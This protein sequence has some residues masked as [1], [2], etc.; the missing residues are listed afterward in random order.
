MFTLVLISE[1]SVHGSLTPCV[2]AEE[3]PSNRIMWKQKMF[4]SLRDGRKGRRQ[5]EKERERG[6]ER[7]RKGKGEERDNLRTICSMCESLVRVG[8]ILPIETTAVQIS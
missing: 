1:G 2:W 7:E 4:I 8:Q 5:K 6:D 3:Y